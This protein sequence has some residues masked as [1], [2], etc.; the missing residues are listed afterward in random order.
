MLFG[1]RKGSVNYGVILSKLPETTLL[2]SGFLRLLILN[3]PQ[4]RMFVI[5][6]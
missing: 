4:K 2:R 3:F 5:G 1:V 6:L